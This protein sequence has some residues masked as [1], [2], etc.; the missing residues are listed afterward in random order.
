VYH[1]FFPSD[2]S[3]YIKIRALDGQFVEH[4]LLGLSAVTFWGKCE[5]QKAE[6]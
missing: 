4:K 1:Y 6:K 3:G 2:K 5:A